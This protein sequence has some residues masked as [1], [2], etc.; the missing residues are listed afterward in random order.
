MF[1]LVG[2]WDIFLDLPDSAFNRRETGKRLCLT[3]YFLNFYLT[4]GGEW[5][6]GLEKQVV[7]EFCILFLMC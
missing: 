5:E 6:L 3:N 1:S 2:K 7:S 4:F